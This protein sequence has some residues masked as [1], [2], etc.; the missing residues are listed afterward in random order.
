M[1][2]YLA[3]TQGLLGLFEA[4]MS[5]SEHKRAKE[6]AE[7]IWDAMRPVIE[8]HKLNLHETMTAVLTCHLAIMQIAWEQI[9]EYKKE[10]E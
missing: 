4:T 8:K 2:K 1:E 10:M 6:V 3:Q 5:E 9:N 7:E